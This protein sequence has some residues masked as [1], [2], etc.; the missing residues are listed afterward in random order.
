VGWFIPPLLTGSDMLFAD[1]PLAPMVNSIRR[2]MA[3][4]DAECATLSS[5]PHRIITKKPGDYILRED[6]NPGHCVVVLDGLTYACRATGDGGRQILAIHLP[7]DIANVSG[8]VLPNADCS[9]RSLTH[10]RIALV[11][12]HV[13]TDAAARSPPICQAFALQTMLDISIARAWM[14]SLGRRSARQRVS[15]LICELMLRQKAVGLSDGRSIAWP[16]TQEQVADATGLTPVH[17]NRTVRGL[18]ED[19]LIIV[20]RRSLLVEN[21]VELCRAGDFRPAY[22]HQSAAD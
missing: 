7:G 22:L 10:T 5:L 1:T 20:E 2:R 11:Q 21:W 14:V 6:G 12:R 8:V 13:M 9:I 17:V 3:L 4:S 19:G 15:H 18:R 16:L